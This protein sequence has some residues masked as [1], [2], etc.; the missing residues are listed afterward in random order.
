MNTQ[1]ITINKVAYTVKFGVKSDL[2]LAK[3]WGL[4]KPSEVFVKIEK[5]L[6]LTPNEEPEIEQLVIIS[7]LVLSGI[8]SADA[9]APVDE[10]DVYRA[11]LTDVNQMASL[12]QLFIENQPK[13]K[14]EA[15]KNVNPDRRKKK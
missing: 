15:K 12:I 13:I 7:Q 11:I 6:S 9:T 8:Q 3:I 5:G 4:T 1:T 2:I 10:D 14:D